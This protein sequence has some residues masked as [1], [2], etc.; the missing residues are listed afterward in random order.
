[1]S[2][3]KTLIV[4]GLWTK[5]P[6]LIQLLGICPLLAI[7]TTLVNGL[8]LGIATTMVLICT[9]S[10]VSLIRHTLLPSVRIL[11]FVMIISSLVT[12]IDLLTNAFFHEL[13]GVL[14][15]FIPL[16]I[17]NCTILAQAESVASRNSIGK[18]II[19]G[20]SA[21]LGFTAV[22]LLLGGLR[23]I[24]GRGSL[25]SG[26]DMLLGDSATDSF[27]KFPFDGALVAILPP[28]AF[29]GLAI[30]IALRN[31][32]IPTATIEQRLETNISESHG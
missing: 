10:I 14:G 20:C 30:L 25:F 1:M 13:H 9:N 2:D 29:F 32:F 21:G 7:T 5:N 17:T 23:E 24:I 18:C 11:I 22:L 4:D 28:G 15:L 6:A 12:T 3:I 19:S 26:I 16:I 8:A 27:I 31:L